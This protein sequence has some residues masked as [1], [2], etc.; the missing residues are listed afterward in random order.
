MREVSAGGTPNNCLITHTI[1]N[2]V[3]IFKI[4]QKSSLT[5][6]QANRELNSPVI[7]Y[8]CSVRIFA[9]LKDIRL[10]VP[11][12]ISTIHLGMCSRFSYFFPAC[13]SHQQ[14]ASGLRLLCGV[15]SSRSSF[16]RSAFSRFYKYF[17]WLEITEFLFYQIYLFIVEWI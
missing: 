9:S 1:Q 7:S 11:I 4:S 2:S 15:S 5:K 6:S 14:L 3:Y 13:R 12:L 16:C 8:I 10:N 17:S